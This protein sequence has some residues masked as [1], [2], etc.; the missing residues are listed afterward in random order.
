LIAVS[1]ISVRFDDE[2]IEIAHTLEKE[3]LEILRFAEGFSL[4]LFEKVS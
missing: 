1:L 2:I 4:D 3:G